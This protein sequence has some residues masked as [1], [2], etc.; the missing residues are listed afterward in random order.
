M[1][2]FILEMRA[3]VD[4]GVNEHVSVESVCLFSLY[5]C[6]C[7]A[8]RVYCFAPGHVSHWNRTSDLSGTGQVV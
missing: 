5:V 4:F 1:P 7:S 8:G 6:L 3:S 2:L